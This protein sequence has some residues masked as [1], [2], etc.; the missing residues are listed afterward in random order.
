[1]DRLFPRLA[2]LERAVTLT[3]IPSVMQVALTGGL[4]DLPLLLRWL[5][6]PA[7][8]GFVTEASYLGL[9][10]LRAPFGATDPLWEHTASNFWTLLG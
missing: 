8:L 4:F 10:R 7:R 1:M 5:P 3:T 2:A 6:V 9:N